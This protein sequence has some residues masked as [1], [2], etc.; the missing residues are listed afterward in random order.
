MQRFEN[1]GVIKNDANFEQDK[2]RNFSEKI[3]E[4]KFNKTWKKDD[5]VDLFHTM[6]P[7]F[8]HKETGKYLDSKM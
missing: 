7:N 5:I 8:G 2:L 6:I 4:M 3:S 1:L